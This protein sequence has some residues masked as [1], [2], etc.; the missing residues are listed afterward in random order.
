MVPDEIPSGLEAGV[1]AG[2]GLRGS[3]RAERVRPVVDREESGRALNAVAR[4]RD[5]HQSGI[6]QEGVSEPELGIGV[7]HYDRRLDV[8]AGRQRFAEIRRICFDE[9][10]HV[11]GHLP[12]KQESQS[13]GEQ[14]ARIRYRAGV[15]DRVSL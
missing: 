2:R 13:P 9:E 15:V 14:I 11:L 6:D 7:L 5:E 8:L 12:A 10:R 1:T 4:E 3:A